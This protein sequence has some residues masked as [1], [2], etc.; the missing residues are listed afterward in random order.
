MPIRIKYICV[1][2]ASAVK[3]DT[4]MLPQAYLVDRGCVIYGL[5][6]NQFKGNHRELKY[7]ESQS[8]G[9]EHC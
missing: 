5:P 2:E 3:S 4:D 1:A 6:I 9:P 8:D 7:L